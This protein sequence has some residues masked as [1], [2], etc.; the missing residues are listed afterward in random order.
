MKYLKFRTN[1]EKN[2]RSSKAFAQAQRLDRL[3]FF[4]LFVLLWCVGQGQ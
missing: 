3:A 2:G 1:G 4:S